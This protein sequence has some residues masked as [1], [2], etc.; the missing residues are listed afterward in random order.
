MDF[1]RFVSGVGAFTS[2]PWGYLG[3]KCMQECRT[4]KITLSHDSYSI[5]LLFGLPIKIVLVEVRWSYFIALQP[6]LKNISDL[7]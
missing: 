2:V 4:L 5:F 7:T 1:G 6:V 3:N